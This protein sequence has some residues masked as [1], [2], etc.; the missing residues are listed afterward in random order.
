MMHEVPRDADK[1]VLD[2]DR[3]TAI[4]RATEVWKGQ[5]ID[6]GGRNTLLYY[7]D[8]TVGTL[9]LGPGS[10]AS[11]VAVDALLGS[12]AVSLS[13]LFDEERRANAA[14]RAR[15]VRA[16]A[17]ENFEE[18]GLRTLFLGW[19]M[20][21]WANSRG[22]TVP[23]APVLLRQAAVN[24]KG[25]AEESFELSLPGEWEV[26]PTLLFVLETDFEVKFDAGD[27][28][29]LL[30]DEGQGAP[31]PTAVFDRLRKAADTVPGF[32]ITPRVVLG[33]FSY[34]KLPMV[35]DLEAGIDALV[36]SDLICAIAGHAPSQQA[37]IDRHPSVA[38]DDPDRTPPSDEFLVLDADASQSYIINAAVGGGDL[39][40]EGPPGTGKSQTIANLIATLAARGQRILFVAEKR[41]AIEAVLGRLDRLGLEDLVLDLHDGVGPKRELAR[42]LGKA[43]SDASS[44]ARPELSDLQTTLVRRRTELMDHNR[45]LHQRRAPWGVSAY[46]AQCRMIAVPETARSACRLRGTALQTLDADAYGLG[47]EQLRTYV[48]LGGLRIS[49]AASPWASALAA[50]TVPT[51]AEAE[52]AS[53]A[54]LVTAGHTWPDTSAQLSRTIIECGL[55][56]PQ[57]VATW[58]STFELL[59][60]VDATLSAF[61][62]AIFT[63]PLDELAGAM[64]PAAKGAAAR[65]FARIGNGAYRSARKQ[66]KASLNPGRRLSTAELYGAITAAAGQQATWAEVSAD[67]GVPRLPGDLA[68]VEGSY[69]QLSSELRALGAYIGAADLSRVDTVTLTTQLEALAGDTETLYRLPELTGLRASLWRIGLGPLVDEL[70][71]RNVDVDTALAALEWVWLASIVEHLSFN[72]P[73]VGAFDGRVQ[74]RDVAD[75]RR[76]DTDHIASGP[77]R[78]LRAVAERITAVRDQYPE[79]SQLVTKQAALKQRFLPIRDLYQAAPDVL[80]A[81]KPC[82]A[83]SPLLVS[84]LLPMQRCFDVVIFDEASQVTPPDAV[85][86]LARAERAIVAGDPHQLPPTN[87]FSPSGGG[88][89]EE[90]DTDLPGSLT[91]DI[92]SV[93]DQMAALLPPPIGTR[94][95]GWHY[96]SRDERLIAF[97]NAQASLYDYSLTTFPG[98]ARDDTI[99]HVHVPFRPGRPGQEDSTAAEVSAV[100]EL[101]A[102]HARQRPQQSLGVITMGIKHADRIEETLRRARQSDNTLDAFVTA[103]A[104]TEKLFVKNLERVQG[105]ERD[106]IILTVGYGK[107][108]DGRMQYRFGPLNN[109]GGERRLNVAITRSRS[110]MTAVSSFTS[111]DLDP[112]RLHSEGARMLGRYLAYAESRGTN[113]GEA[114][115]AKPDLNPFERDVETQLTKAG[116]PLIPQWGSSGY[117]IDYAAQHPTTPGRMV[118]AIECDGVTYHTSPTARDRDRLRQEHLERLGWRFHRIWSIDWFRHRDAEVARAVAAY[119][120]AVA[121]SDSANGPHL[122]ADP[123]ETWQ[124]KSAAPVPPPCRQGPIPL[125]PGLGTITA[126][127]HDELVALI[128]WLESDTLLRT[129]EDLISEATAA[130]GFQKR[131]KNIVAA[132]HAAT[133]DARRQDRTR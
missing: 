93:L 74:D 82:W 37:I 110:R 131:G 56:A 79:Q 126:Y 92:E 67:D 47:R 122:T 68:G 52:A 15:T 100:V 73:L 129:E 27:L 66:L 128:R 119:H 11:E 49:A 105:D 103:H 133:E 116:I 109:N 114:A 130:L 46:E 29:D 16:K 91:Q 107:N 18:R 61:E 94:T 8:L 12:H 21:T 28:L 5:L 60:G 104:A 36:G 22:P 102:D 117:W 81:L 77:Q 26:N 99:T 118:L 96:R 59:D 54:A 120:A 10:C 132:L 41:A 51:S 30:D 53:T 7:K 84:Q 45:S 113:L 48:G 72:D 35:I 42:K 125:R 13:T 83:M 25:R 76:A 89:D 95:L 9:D 78:V 90:D 75:Y 69:G 115:K 32:S 124:S 50:G 57:D 121:A 98:S 39:V 80:G 63:R 88:T 87:F 70:T 23:A 19:G 43:L 2:R 97:S 123:D 86:A 101:I 17:A 55:R 71:T 34:A 6:L 33:N 40:V 3:L 106:A 85:G 31:D 62:P 44:I 24:P 4:E 111:A 20:A 127:R 38:L 1:S 58:A 112:E 108:A 14:K 64:A 65:F